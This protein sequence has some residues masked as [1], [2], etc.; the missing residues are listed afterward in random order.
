M[1]NEAATNLLTVQAP[2]FWHSGRTVPRMMIE[3][4]LALLPAAIMAT[5]YYGMDA[6]RVIGISC[7][8]AVVAE[9][10]CCKIMERDISVDDYSALVTGLLF[11]Y[12]LPASAPWWLV[13]IGSAVSIMAAKMLFGGLGANPLCAPL[14]GWAILRVSWPDQMSVI[15]TMLNTDLVDFL[16]YLK[17]YGADS[18]KDASLNLMYIGEQLGG[19]GAAQVLAVLLGGI[20]M[21]IRGHIRIYIPLAFIIGVFATAAIFYGMDSEMYASPM[22][23]LVAGSTLFGAFFLATDTA[24]SPVGVVPMIIF[25]LLCGVM[26]VIIRVYGIYPDGVPFAILL[27]NLF[28]PLIDLIKPKPI[29]AR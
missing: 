11:A 4:V 19:L 23:H 5:V 8:T 20:F 14:V 28:T 29:G 21:L 27:A 18:V 26:V 24:S 2:P 3:T 6:V 10:L 25:G 1:A 17:Y 13:M 12:I 22:F 9:A 16:G 7:A 15:G